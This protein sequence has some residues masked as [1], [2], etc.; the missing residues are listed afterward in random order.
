VIVTYSD[1]FVGFPCRV[2]GGFGYDRARGV[3]V[4]WDV[5][6]GPW[7]KRLVGP[8]VVEKKKGEELEEE[9]KEWLDW[10]NVDSKDL[11]F[12]VVFGAVKA[13]GET[14][15]VAREVTENVDLFVGRYL[16]LI[17]TAYIGIKFL[18]FKV[19]PDIIPF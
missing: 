2:L 16:T 19:F 8:P 17:A 14:S 9:G 5:G 10:S 12:V 3:A 4:T 7:K 15:K 6:V 18:H 11:P 13:I 1:A